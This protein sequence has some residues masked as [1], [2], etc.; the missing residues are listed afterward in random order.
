MIGLGPLEEGHGG[1]GSTME[2]YNYK[3]TKDLG[4]NI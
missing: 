3:C 4:Y 1:E 2:E